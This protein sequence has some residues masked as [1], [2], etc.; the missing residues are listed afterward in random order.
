MTA[1][2]RSA[3]V[4]PGP[5]AHN[6]GRTASREDLRSWRSFTAASAPFRMARYVFC[7]LYVL[8]R[9]V[10]QHSLERKRPWCSY[11]VDQGIQIANT[12]NSWSAH[13]P[14]WEFHMPLSADRRQQ[15]GL[16]CT[17]TPPL[18]VSRP[19]RRLL[20]KRIAVIPR[21]CQKLCPSSQGYYV[22]H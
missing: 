16:Y 10:S 20:L 1:R 17:R 9:P 5:P 14:S 3:L 2:W 13:A 22:P 8:P 4:R 6:Q 19:L 18:S 21:T 7:A 15:N 11:E 12:K